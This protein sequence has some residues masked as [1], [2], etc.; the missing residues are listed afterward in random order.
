MVQLSLYAAPVQPFLEKDRREAG[1]RLGFLLL[2]SIAI[3]ASCLRMSVRSELLEAVAS[4]L[5]SV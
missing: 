4:L 2:D 1:V 3:I 5:L